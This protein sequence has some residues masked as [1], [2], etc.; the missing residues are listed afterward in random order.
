MPSGRGGM[1]VVLRLTSLGETP[2]GDL[3]DDQVERQRGVRIK[4]NQLVQAQ[5]AMS[6]GI[7]LTVFHTSDVP[8]VSSRA[9]QCCIHCCG[10]MAQ[11][12]GMSLR[13][14]RLD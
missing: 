7:A 13:W 11:D 9:T 3:D 14:Q 1:F 5:N 10:T 6:L 2:K 12:Q 4:L 8:H